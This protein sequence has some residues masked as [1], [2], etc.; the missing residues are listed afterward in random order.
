MRNERASKSTKSSLPTSKASK[1]DLKGKAFRRPQALRIAETRSKIIEAAIEFIDQNSYHQATIHKVAKQADVSVGAVQ[2]HFSCKFDLMISVVEESFLQLTQIISELELEGEKLEKRLDLF[3]NA[4]WSFCN[5]SRYQCSMQILQSIRA[6][7][8]D[9]FD[10]WLGEHL[11][12]IIETGF[13]QWHEVVGDSIMDQT[14]CYNTLLFIFAALSGA[15][16]HY[17]INRDLNG[18]KINLEELKQLLSLKLKIKRP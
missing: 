11:G 14:E 2:H 12:Q 1:A 18:A 6:E 10:N 4:C 16:Q 15:A 5:S 7:A 13:A 17:R 3:L 8:S 9:N